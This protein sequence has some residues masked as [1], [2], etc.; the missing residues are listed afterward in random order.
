[1][2]TAGV[3]IPWLTVLTYI[4]Y[5]L[6]ATEH[7]DL[8]YLFIGAYIFSLGSFIYLNIPDYPSSSRFYN[9]TTIMALMFLFIYS[10]VPWLNFTGLVLL[11]L[12]PVSL[13]LFLYSFIQSENRKL[14]KISLFILT[15]SSIYSFF[16]F[17]FYKSKHQPSIKATH[18][19]H[20]IEQERN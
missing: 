4:F 17:I 10:D 1:M 19:S 20:N 16:S 12:C 11:C 7:T 5:Y 3:T 13:Y 2:K 14:F 8:I 6:T 18:C 15:G 9:L